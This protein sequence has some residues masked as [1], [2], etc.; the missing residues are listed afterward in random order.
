MD[1]KKVKMN[2]ITELDHS[3]IA[4]TLHESLTAQI[5]STKK[6]GRVKVIHLL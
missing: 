4:D 5:A 1:K 2:G 6:K 3:T